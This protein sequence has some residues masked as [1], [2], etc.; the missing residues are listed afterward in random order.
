M[1]KT[2]REK[3]PIQVR[4]AKFAFAARGTAGLRRDKELMHVSDK[5]TAL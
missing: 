2:V 1:V 4:L 3:W 5:C